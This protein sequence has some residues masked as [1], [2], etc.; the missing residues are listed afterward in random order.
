M[1]R[2]LI[3]DP[4]YEYESFGDADFVCFRDKE[5]NDFEKKAKQFIEKAKGCGIKEIFLSEHYLI[6][7]KLGATGVHLTSK[8]SIFISEAKKIE[9]KVIISTH[10]EAEIEEAIRKEA[11]FITYSPIFGTPNKGRAKGVEDLKKM[12]LR[13][14]IP[15]IALGGII[16]DDK[17]EAI[18]ESGAFGFASIRYF[19]KGD[20]EV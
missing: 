5:C 20:S 11:D 8:Q 13:Y 6:A 7:K 4:S 10:T 3:T 17:I 18:K 16:D 19:A 2:Y 12:V 14:N 15:I 9:L 1:I